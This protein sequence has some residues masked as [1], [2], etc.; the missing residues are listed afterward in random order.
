[1][2]N[3]K[4]VLFAGAAGVS[5]V[6]FLRGKKHAGFL[7]AGTGLTAL[8]LEYPD[9]IAAMR[10]NLPRYITRGTMALDLISKLSRRR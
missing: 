7:A 4:R 9:T 8:A 2:K 5:A 10:G 6:Q 1:M 3:W